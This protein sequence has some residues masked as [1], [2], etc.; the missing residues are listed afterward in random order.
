M[1]SDPSAGFTEA[2]MAEP[3][4]RL[5]LPFAKTGSRELLE[6]VR[7]GEMRLLAVGRSR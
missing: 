3:D 4:R 7:R 6:A 2:I 5:V 1:A